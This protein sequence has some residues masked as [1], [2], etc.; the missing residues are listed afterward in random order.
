MWRALRH[1]SSTVCGKVPLPT[2]GKKVSSPNVMPAMKRSGSGGY[3]ASDSEEGLSSRANLPKNC[4]YQIILLEL[5]ILYFSRL[6][7]NYYSF[8]SL[9]PSL[10]FYVQLIIVSINRLSFSHFFLFFLLSH[11]FFMTYAFFLPI[12]WPREGARKNY[13]WNE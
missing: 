6:I 4:A 5:G 7:D 11:F 8:I 3:C 13:F 9:G 12:C 2:T 1:S 10:F